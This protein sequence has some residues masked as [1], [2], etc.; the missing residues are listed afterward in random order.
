MNVLATDEL[1]VFLA[2]NHLHVN[3]YSKE[4]INHF[5]TMLLQRIYP[6]M[7]IWLP[8]PQLSKFGS[9]WSS[10]VCFWCYM[11][12]NSFELLITIYAYAIGQYRYSI[13]WKLC[14]LCLV[15]LTDFA[16]NKWSFALAYN[17]TDL[18]RNEYRS[19]SQLMSNL[20]PLYHCCEGMAILSDFVNWFFWLQFQLFLLLVPLSRL[21]FLVQRNCKY[22]VHWYYFHHM[23][24]NYHLQLTS[25]LLK[26]Q[27]H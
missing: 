16:V 18:V 8:F 13:S 26:I 9:F 2:A 23:T 19:S 4:L 3:T 12:N 25:V 5:C 7:L 21:C 17:F 1:L 22:N 27:L 11:I 14:S 15:F 10:V 20:L 6:R 24:L